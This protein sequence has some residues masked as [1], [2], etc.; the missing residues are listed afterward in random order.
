[1]KIHPYTFVVKSD[2]PA[3]GWGYVMSPRRGP[4]Q[5][6]GWGTSDLN[7]TLSPPRGGD[8]TQGAGTS[9]RGA[10]TSLGGGDIESPPGGGDITQGAGTLKC[11]IH[12]SRA[13]PPPCEGYPPPGAGMCDVPAA[14]TS[15]FSVMKSNMW[16]ILLHNDGIH[17]Q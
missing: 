15:H 1:M 5:G 8:I 7:Q 9:H 4:S 6:G 11:V 16:Q 13:S 2:I 14:G 10:G 3:P 17:T 12:F